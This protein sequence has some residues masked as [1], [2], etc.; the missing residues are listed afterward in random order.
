MRIGRPHLTYS[1]PLSHQDPLGGSV[2]VPPCPRTAGVGW[3]AKVRPVKVLDDK[4]S[5]TDATVL[6]WAVKNGVRVINMSLG[7][8]GDN[9]VPQDGDDRQR[10]LR[11]RT[12]RSA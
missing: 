1:G 8:E 9:P 7:G 2:V 10:E 4:G 3:A 5:G 6:N 12:R 11:V